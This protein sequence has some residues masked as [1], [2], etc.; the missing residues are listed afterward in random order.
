[1]SAGDDQLSSEDYRVAVALR[2]ALHRFSQASEQVL[3]RNSLTTERCELLL[4]IKSSENDPERVTVSVPTSAL[5]IAQ[6][7]VTQARAESRMPGC[8]DVRSPRTMR[9]SATCGAPDAASA[10]SREPSRTSGRS[11][12]G[13]R[14]SSQ[15]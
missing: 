14:R 9:G 1:V 10:S 2:A 13:S 11:A 3:D 5:G 7:S 12:P 8:S 4:A 6:S 15:L